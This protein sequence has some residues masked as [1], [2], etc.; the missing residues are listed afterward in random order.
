MRLQIDQSSRARQ[1]RV[2]WRHLRQF[3]PQKCFQAERIVASPSDSALR[4]DTL[5]VTHRQQTKVHPRRKT[6]ATDRLALI[7][8][9]ALLLNKLVKSLILQDLVHPIVEDVPSRPRQISR[10]NPHRLLP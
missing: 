7:K 5:E 9:T 2:I 6:R 4:I 10:V 1:G 3:V 8:T